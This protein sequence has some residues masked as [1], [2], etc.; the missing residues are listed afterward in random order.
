MKKANTKTMNAIEI[1]RVFTKLFAPQKSSI[2]TR[3]SPK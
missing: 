1:E 2:T 3:I